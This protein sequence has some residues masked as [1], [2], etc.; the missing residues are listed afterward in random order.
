MKCLLVICLFV[1]VSCSEEPLDVY[2]TIGGDFVLHDQFGDELFITMGG[3]CQGCGSAAMTMKQGVEVAIR[4]AVPE[5]EGINDATDHTSVRIHICKC[6]RFF[7]LPCQCCAFGRAAKIPMSLH[8][9]LVL[10]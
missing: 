1:A 6:G 3:G 9:D 5:I 2:D 10:I 8:R 4:D 7:L